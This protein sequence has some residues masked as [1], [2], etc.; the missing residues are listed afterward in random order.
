MLSGQGSNLLSILKKDNINKKLNIISIVSNNK[1][2]NEIKKFLFMN[3][4]KTRIYE[5]QLKLKTNKTELMEVFNCGI[6]MILV[7]DKKYYKKFYNRK[8]F[9]VIGQ[10]Q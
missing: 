6:G 5:N 7:I 3:K 2:S 9:S 4:M 10:I 1:I 8:L